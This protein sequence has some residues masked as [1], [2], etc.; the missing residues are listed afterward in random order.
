MD[1]TDNS[2]TTPNYRTVKQFCDRHE[3]ATL[4]GIRNL[5]FH[6]ETNGFAKCIK[7]MG[8]RILLD[9][10]AIFTWIDEQSK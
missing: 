7:R 1:T 10:D 6:A 4:G 3:W 2:S 5:I 8:R 9:E